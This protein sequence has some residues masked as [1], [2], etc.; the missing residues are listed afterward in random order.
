MAQ[1]RAHLLDPVGL[2]IT[3][4]DVETDE[5]F[6]LNDHFKARD[7]TLYLVCEVTDRESPLGQ[8][9]SAVLVAG[10]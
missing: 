2:E 6:G 4:I 7:S 8:E 1:V 9:L 10:P 3:T 5:H